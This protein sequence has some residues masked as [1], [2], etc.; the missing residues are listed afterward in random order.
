MKLTLANLPEDMVQSYLDDVI[1]FAKTEDQAIE[2]LRI[3]F[4]R[5]KDTNLTFS[6]AKCEFLTKETNFLGFRLSHEGLKAHP[7]KIKSMIQ[8]PTPNSTKKL[9]SALGL[10]AYYKRFIKNF[11]AIAKHLYALTAHNVPFVWGPAQEA[12]FN[13]LKDKLANP[14]VLAFPRFDKE[15]K[16]RVETDASNYAISAILS[17]NVKGVIQPV[18]FSSRLLNPKGAKGKRYR[19]GTISIGFCMKTIRFNFNR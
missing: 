11:S 17:N 2:R 12:S 6:P 7:D 4:Q 1:I 5:F 9:K 15:N 10:F 3:I 19:K 8:L 18:C 14:T 16:Y 13:T